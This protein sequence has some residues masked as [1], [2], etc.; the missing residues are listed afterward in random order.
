MNTTITETRSVV[1]EREMPHPPEKIWRALTETPLL[2]DWLMKNDFRL[3]VGH[4]FNF[5]A[6]PV[7]GW[8]GVIGCEVLEVEPRRRLSYSWDS[9]GVE[10]VVTWTLEPTKDGTMVRMEQA[11]FRADQRPNFQGAKLAWQRFIGSLER[12]A[13]GLDS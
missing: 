3:V 10:S 12:V 1:I 11:G 13:G 8:D 7:G 6:D 5:R 9:L 4:K 2:D